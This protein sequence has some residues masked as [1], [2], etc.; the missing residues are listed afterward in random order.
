MTINLQ[1]NSEE[2]DNTPLKKNVRF[3]GLG[4]TSWESD[5]RDTTNVK[6]YDIGEDER[7]D[8]DSEQFGL[9]IFKDCIGE[10]CGWAPDNIVVK[11]LS[12]VKPQEAATEF[13]IEGL[14]EPIP[15]EGAPSIIIVGTVT[16]HTVSY[17]PISY[18]DRVL[19]LLPE[20]YYSVSYVKIPFDRVIKVKKNLS[21]WQQISMVLTYLPAYQAL[22]L[23]P[24][25]LY[26][27]R[28]LI[29]SGLGPVNQALIHLC[30]ASKADVVYVPCEDKYAKMVRQMGALPIDSQHTDWGPMLINS[31]DVVFDSI[32]E[33]KFI[34][35]KATV[36]KDGYMVVTGHKLLN[37]EIGSFWYGWNKRDIDSRLK[38]SKRI[39]QYN[40][41]QS[42]DSNRREFEK[43]FKDIDRMV[44]EGILPIIGYEVKLQ[45]D[46]KSPD[47]VTKGTHNT[48]LSGYGVTTIPQH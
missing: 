12:V 1:Q 27:Q 4:S 48:I 44:F 23:V 22:N 33:N 36:V 16:S 47:L 32:G 41:M 40:F 28:I 10:I 37:S 43:N 18:Q 9:S 21:P 34:T 5:Y 42:F 15:V 2:L 35:S 25:D 19:A 20:K 11:V 17:C 24:F 45:K 38:S 26:K 7:D 3:E 6:S 30:V 14:H 13:Q 8:V 46:Q 39:S 29:C 31:I